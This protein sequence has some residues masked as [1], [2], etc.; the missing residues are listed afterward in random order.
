MNTTDPQR[1][2]GAEPI[3]V[4][5]P[6]VRY[7][8]TGYWTEYVSSFETDSIFEGMPDT[9]AFHCGYAGEVVRFPIAELAAITDALVEFRR[10]VEAAAAVPA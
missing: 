7:E 2:M 8:T 4:T 1:R 5:T 9:V 10:Q 6:V 3:T